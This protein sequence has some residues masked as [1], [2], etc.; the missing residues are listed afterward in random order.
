MSS[1]FVIVVEKFLVDL[2]KAFEG[3]DDKTMKVVEL[4]KVEQRS[5]TMEEFVQKLRRVVRESRYKERLLIK[6]FKREINRIIR[7]KLIETE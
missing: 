1:L 4:K 5:K 6:E 3:G 7:R 2:K